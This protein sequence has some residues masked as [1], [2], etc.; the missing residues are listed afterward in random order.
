MT[1]PNR[2]N[3]LHELVSDDA[4]HISRRVFT[5]E[6]VY[7]WEKQFIFARSWLYLCHESQL[8][9]IGDYLTTYMCETPVIVARG[10]D[11]K[12][13]V[14]VNSCSHR[15]LPVCRNDRGNTKRRRRQHRAEAL[16]YKAKRRSCAPGNT[17][18]LTECPQLPG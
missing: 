2:T 6:E 18:R 15:G 8:P 10:E 9:N 3:H 4:C 17:R 12:I 16:R 7:A 13:H 5:S 1:R 14:S 11:G